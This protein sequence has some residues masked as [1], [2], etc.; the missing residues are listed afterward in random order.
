MPTQPSMIAEVTFRLVYLMIV[1]VL[2]WLALLARSDAAKDAEILTL[3]HEVT[4]LRR[5]NPRP[6]LTWLD[7]AVLSALGR[8]LPAPLRLWGFRMLH[9][10]LTSGDWCPPVVRHDRRCVAAA[11]IPDG[12]VLTMEQPGVAPSRPGIDGVC[13]P[14]LTRAAHLLGV[15]EEGKRAVALDTQEPDG[16]RGPLQSEAVEHVCGTVAFGAGHC[17]GHGVLAAAVPR[18]AGAA[19]EPTDAGLRVP[20]CALGS[21][22]STVSVSYDAA[23]RWTC[24]TIHRP[25]W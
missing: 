4:L 20:F 11:A 15:D 24:G 8:L 21:H 25:G 23:V 18:R 5:T 2:S 17:V 9:M 10:P 3:R 19:V 1:R 16:P 14:L 7:R 6:T 13:L 22:A 12:L